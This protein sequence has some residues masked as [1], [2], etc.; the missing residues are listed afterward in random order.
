MLTLGHC[1]PLFA[2][3]PAAQAFRSELATV[4]RNPELFWIDCSAPSDWGSFALV[5]P[6]ALCVPAAPA[7]SGWRNPRAMTSPR[8]HTLFDTATYAR[9]KKDKRRMHM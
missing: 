7:G 2:L 3:M 8:F 4:G 5:D 9:L 6:V 1:I